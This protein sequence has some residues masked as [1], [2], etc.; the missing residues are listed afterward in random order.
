MGIRFEMPRKPS[1]A[2]ARAELSA[3]FLRSFQADF[4]AHGKEV[5]ERMRLESPAKYAEIASRL[6]AASDPPAENSFKDCNSMEDIGRRLLKSVGLPEPD[7]AAIQAAI[8]ANDTFVARLEA[9]VQASGI[10]PEVM[11]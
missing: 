2:S 11:N 1:Q 9:I 8:E 10:N 6:I 5:I 4:K 3:D 7:E